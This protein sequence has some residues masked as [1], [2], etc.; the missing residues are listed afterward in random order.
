MSVQMHVTIWLKLGNIGQEVG[1]RNLL[2]GYNKL[3]LASTYRNLPTRARKPSGSDVI[4]GTIR[5]P[6]KNLFSFCRNAHFGRSR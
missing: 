2:K 1:G 3:G 4:P 5:S 6:S